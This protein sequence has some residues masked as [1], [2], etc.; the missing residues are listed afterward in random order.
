MVS[1]ERGSDLSNGG[2]PEV[3]LEDGD[4]GLLIGQGDVDELVQ[5][6]GPEDGRV[7]DVG[8]VGGTNNEDVLLAGHAVHLCQDLV[9]DTVGGS[10][11]ITHIATTGLGNGVQLIKEQH[12]RSS[13]TS[14]LVNK[15]GTEGQL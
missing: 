12:A 14:L 1:V 11:T 15:Y 2:L 6:A 4:A 10:A 13:L 9:D 7:D 5:T 3:G 8:P